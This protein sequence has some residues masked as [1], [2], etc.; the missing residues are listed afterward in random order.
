MHILVDAD[1]CPVKG[2]IRAE[3]EAARRAGRDVEVVLFATVDHR[4]A[5]GDRWVCVAAGRDAVDHALFSAIAAGDVVVTADYGLAALCLGRRAVVLHPDGWRYAEP[6]M[7][8]LL[9]ER[10]LAARARRA[11]TRVR[12]PRPRRAAD[13]LAFGAAIRAVLAD[14][15]AAPPEAVGGPPAVP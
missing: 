10:D 12:G 14:A 1:A 7:T 5:E 11:G 13:D 8:A 3:A 4:Q 2:V 9:A 15:G 6:A